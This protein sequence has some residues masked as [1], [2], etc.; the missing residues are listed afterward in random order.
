[1]PPLPVS[2]GAKRRGAQR[3][4]R[5]STSLPVPPPGR[6]TASRRPPVPQA[7]RLQRAEATHV[8]DAAQRG[9]GTQRCR[10]RRLRLRRRRPLPTPEE[11]RQPRG[12]PCAP[13]RGWP[14][15]VCG[16]CAADDR[17]CPRVLG[18]PFAVSCKKLPAEVVLL[19]EEHKGKRDRRV[20]EGDRCT[21]ARTLQGQVVGVG[22]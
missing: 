17:R 8:Q 10:R 12:T 4:Q 15:L 14:S 16:A 5:P 9:L 22:G 3:P 2:A 19:R 11:G 13:S 18:C 21:R 6:H 1:M 20:W 7:A